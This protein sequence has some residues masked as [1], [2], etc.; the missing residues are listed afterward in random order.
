MLIVT[1]PPVHQDD[2]LKTIIEHPLVDAVRYNTGVDSPYTP[3]EVVRSIQELA[4]PLGKPVFID[5]KGKQLRVIEWAN[6]PEGPILLNHRIKVALPARVHLRGEATSNLKAVVDGNHIF[7]DPLPKYAVGRGQAV[8]IISP[9]LEI[10]GGLLPLDYEYIEAGMQHGVAGFMLSFVESMKDVRELEDALQS[11]AKRP[12]IILKIESQAG[13]NF[14]AQ[15]HYASLTRYQLMAARDDLMIHVGPYHMPDA[16]RTIREKNPQAICASRILM[17]LAQDG[18][19][20]ADIS[21]LEYMWRGIGYKHFMLSDG[22]SRDHFAAAMDAWEHY[23]ST[24]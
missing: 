15:T 17:G 11:R 8:N 23:W 16:L 13:L 10:E 1:L 20:M 3:D 4:F 7:V 19:S 24:R 22:I 21:D 12:R 14:V 9:S 6:L 18:V 5:L 2:L